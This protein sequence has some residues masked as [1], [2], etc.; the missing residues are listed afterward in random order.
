[1]TDTRQTVGFEACPCG[2]SEFEDP[3]DGMAFAIKCRGC[4]AQTDLYSTPA[5]AVEAWNRRARGA[6]LFE[7]AIDAAIAASR[8]TGAADVGEENG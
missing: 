1:M 5:D 8:S 3:I 2:G 6:H 7:E 4:G